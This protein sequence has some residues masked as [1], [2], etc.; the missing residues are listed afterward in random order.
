MAIFQILYTQVVSYGVWF[1]WSNM[2]SPV[3]GEVPN[4]DSPLKAMDEG[5]GWAHDD[6][7]GNFEVLSSYAHLVYIHVNTPKTPIFG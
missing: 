7:N 3:Q 2:N 5:K 1:A 6:E 4:R